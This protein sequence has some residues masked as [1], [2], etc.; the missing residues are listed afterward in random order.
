M[1]GPDRS[2]PAIGLFLLGG[3]FFVVLNALAKGLT[4]EL[5]PVMVIW[6]RFFFHV[7]VAIA[8]F[9]AALIGLARTPQ[10]GVQLGRS[11]LLM[12][13]TVFNFLALWYLPLADVSAIVFTAPLVVAALSVMILKERV[14]PLR[15]AAI[16]VGLLGALVIIRPGAGGLGLGALLAFG[17]TLA[18]S[19]Y[20]IST[21][22]VREV[23]P[24]VSLIYAGLT[25]VLVF[26]LILPWGWQAP[27]L[28]QWLLLAL[29]GGCGAIGHLMV[30]LALQRLEASRLTPFTYLQLVWSILASILVFGDIP[31]FATL[32]GA[33]VIVASGLFV[34]WLNVREARGALTRHPSA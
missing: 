33:A 6:G 14:T 9:P 10:L 7:M 1:S 24:I 27:S 21:R 28:G 23:Q 31:G 16:L 20:Q 30:I 19:V 29:L 26:S 34:W 15:W 5:G 2:L 4:P 11:V 3:L 13:S 12:L 32:A 8:L 25:G 18:Y 17:C 22:L